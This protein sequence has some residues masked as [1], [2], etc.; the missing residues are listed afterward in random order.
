MLFS[1]RIYHLLPG[2]WP[3]VHC[4]GGQNNRHGDSVCL[5]QLQGQAKTE[6]KHI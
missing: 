6:D 3:A 5:Q 2:S 1:G 4:G